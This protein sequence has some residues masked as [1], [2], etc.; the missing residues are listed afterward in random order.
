MAGIYV[1]IPFCKKA[2]HYCDFHFSTSLKGKEQLIDSLLIEIASRKHELDLDRI[3]SLY[4]G[5]GTPSIL[6]KSELLKIIQCIDQNY[7][8]EPD[9]ELTIECNPDD[10]T[11]NKINDFLE[12]G[13][14]RLSI[15]VQ[16]FDD[17]ILTWMN[18]SHSVLQ[19][20]Q[21]VRQAQKL[22][23]DNISIDLIYGV[24]NT[25]L[26][27]WEFNLNQALELKVQHIS[28]YC[29]TV[30][31]KT[32]LHHHV[33]K[34]KVKMP[35]EEDQAEQFELLIHTLGKNGFD[36]YEVSNFG[37]PNFY[38]QHN[39]S[40]WKNKK[41]LGFGPSAHSFDQKSRKWNV[42]NNAKYMNFI[43]DNKP[44]FE[45]ENLSDN[46]RI[47]ETLMTGLRTKWGV[48]L[49]FLREELK[50]DLLI[51]EKLKINE[52]IQAGKLRIENDHLIATKSGLLL[53]DRMSSDLFVI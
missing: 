30:E 27:A 7:D 20:M 24:P 35:N 52:W 19:S 2:C 10:L 6:S 15:G 47:N 37:L 22:G 4:F 5:G 13:F 21:S 41:Y 12:A 17:R 1:H 43:Q 51:R 8:L 33:M 46:E 25:D 29:L 34:E 31:P 23:F 39:S 11:E 3:S 45:V 32:V 9:L 44:Y 48:D 14:N 16:S 28:A 26:K 18:R 53:S 40:Y 50:F 38:S 36:Q 42:S 49:K